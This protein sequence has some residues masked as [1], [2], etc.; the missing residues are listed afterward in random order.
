VA[1]V[2]AKVGG[3]RF[4]QMPNTAEATARVKSIMPTAYLSVLK[5]GPAFAG[6]L[7][8]TNLIFE[9]YVIMAGEQMSDDA[10]YKVAKVLYEAQDKLAAIAKTFDRY[11]K[12]KLASDRGVPYHPG[13]IK[14]YKEKGIWQGK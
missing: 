1:E 2:N 7:E 11:D 5:P 10:A 12:S 14:Y 3:I 4:L 8:P 13:A 9:D 6:I